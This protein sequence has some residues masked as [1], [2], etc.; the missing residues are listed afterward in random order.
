ML[1]AMYN[2]GK[3]VVVVVVLLLLLRVP[4][5]LIIRII[6]I[7][8]SQRGVRSNVII[9]K[10]AEVY[11]LNQADIGIL[12]SSISFVDNL[13]PVKRCIIAVLIDAG[14]GEGRNLNVESDGLS[15]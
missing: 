1:A 11:I 3:V 15:V 14:S 2:N 13:L 6:G 10:A 4:I 9:I 8:H 7:A 5:I 12:K